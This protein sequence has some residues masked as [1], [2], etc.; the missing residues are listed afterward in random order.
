MCKQNELR[1]AANALLHQIDIGDFVDPHGHSATMLMATHDLMRVLSSGYC[2]EGDRCVC[3][4]DLP[5]V[6]EGCAN[7]VTPNAE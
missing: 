6:R 3:G 1:D 2:T 7:W 4:G 5:R